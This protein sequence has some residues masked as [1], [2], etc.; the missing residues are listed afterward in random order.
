MGDLNVDLLR[1][2]LSN[3]LLNNYMSH[4]LKS[5]NDKPTRFG[6]NK[7]GIKTETCSDHL[8]ARNVIIPTVTLNET[9]ITE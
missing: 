8:H 7:N 3:L 1:K 4:G 6:V 9:G 2:E 5:F